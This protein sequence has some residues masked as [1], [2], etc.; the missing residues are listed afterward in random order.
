LQ[1]LHIQEEKGM[2]ALIGNLIKS[3]QMFQY[4][5]TFCTEAGLL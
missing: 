1:Y 3:V 5:L 2:S 4:R